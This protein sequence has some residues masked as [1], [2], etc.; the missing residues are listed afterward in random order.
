MLSAAMGAGHLQVARELKR[1]LTA[2]GHTV[3][4]ADLLQLM[5]APTGR[6]LGW[7]YPFM[8]KDAP[9]LYDIV[10]RHFFLAPQRQAERASV[11]VRLSLP[12][13]RDLV[14][15]FRPDNVVSTYHLAGVAAA[16]L[17]ASHDLPCLTTT[18]VTTFGVHELWL[19]PA[20]DAYLCITPAAAASVAGRSP[21]AVAVCEPVVRPEF[22]PPALN[23]VL[24]VALNK[25]RALADGAEHLA[26]VVAGSLGLGRAAGAARAVS[27]LPGW[28]AVVVCGRNERLQRELRTANAAVLGWVDNMAELVAAVDVVVDNA[29]G[30]T[31]KEALCAGRPVV[32]FRPLAGHG[33]HDAL[34]ME[35]AGL[36]EVADDEDMLYSALARLS[37][38]ERAAERI[39]RGRS[40]FG[41][42]PAHLI[43]GYCVA[44]PASRAA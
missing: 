1:R 20:T 42:D 9:W 32:T 4:V 17:R 40:L 29:A 27:S 3:A 7:I 12:K 6:A 19:H 22:A 18:M 2:R 37:C 39:K 44:A 25:R 38:P 31:A 24:P 30:S 16:E 28:R 23:G 21:A 13:L 5:P 35:A 33:R 41:V 34:A 26:L 11:P 14:R 36:T 15:R 10:F 43:E 8:A